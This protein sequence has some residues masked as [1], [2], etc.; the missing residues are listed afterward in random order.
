MFIDG[1]NSLMAAGRSSSKGD[2]IIRPE[3]Q[4]KMHE[5]SVHLY[6]KKSGSH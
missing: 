6:Y 5:Y 2:I 4:K 3:E 1:G